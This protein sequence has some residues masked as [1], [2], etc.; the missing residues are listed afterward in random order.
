MSESLSQGRVFVLS[1]AIIIILAL[2]LTWG[3]AWFQAGAMSW[4]KTFGWVWVITCG[5]GLVLSAL[6]VRE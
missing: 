3:L 2:T 5:V 1:R 4:A 6:W